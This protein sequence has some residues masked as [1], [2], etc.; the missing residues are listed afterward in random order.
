MTAAGVSPITIA[1]MLGHSSSSQ[2]VPRY[3]VVLDQNRI[4]AIKK[5]EAFRQSA[6]RDNQ[7]LQESGERLT[8]APSNG[9]VAG[10][11]PAGSLTLIENQVT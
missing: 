6:I 9:E 11:S 4:D 7:K 5:L 2:I 3:A 8:T 1:Q 10:S